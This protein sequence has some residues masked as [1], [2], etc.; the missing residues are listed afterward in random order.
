MS[1]TI[2]PYTLHTVLSEAP[3]VSLTFPSVTRLQ[4]YRQK[5]YGVNS[6]GLFR[7]RTRRMGLSLEIVRVS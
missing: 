7:Y 1:A 4:S 6:T 2:S 3:A 5:I